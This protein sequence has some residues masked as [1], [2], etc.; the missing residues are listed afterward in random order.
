MPLALEGLDELERVETQRAIRAAVILEIALS[1]AIHPVRRDSRRRNGELRNATVGTVQ[2]D[3]TGADDGWV[4]HQKINR[5][6]VKA[7]PRKR[8]RCDSRRLFASS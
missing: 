3:D 2:R 6:D 1:I 8:P 4:A 5:M 7:R